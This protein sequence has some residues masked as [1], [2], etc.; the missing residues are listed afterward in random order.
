MKNIG[1]VDHGPLDLAS[2][3]TGE[4]SREVLRVSGSLRTGNHQAHR[5]AA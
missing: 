3:I 4:P 2:L 5:P 1:D